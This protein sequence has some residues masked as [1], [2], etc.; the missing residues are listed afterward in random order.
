MYHISTD[1][2]GLQK[3]N[4]GY[5]FM[6]FQKVGGLVSNREIEKKTNT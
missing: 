4:K 5:H 3:N 6:V 2:V 1:Y